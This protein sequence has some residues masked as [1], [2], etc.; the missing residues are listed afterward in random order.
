MPASGFLPD[1]EI[2]DARF[3][4]NAG[5]ARMHEPSGSG[6]FIR[7]DP[8]SRKK[9]TQETYERPKTDNAG[10]GRTGG[11]DRSGRVWPVQQRESRQRGFQRRQASTIWSPR[12]PWQLMETRLKSNTRNSS[13]SGERT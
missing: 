6:R 11:T 1:L 7:P 12:W 8:E 10:R 9:Q 13:I 2:T 4:R 5:L 3:G